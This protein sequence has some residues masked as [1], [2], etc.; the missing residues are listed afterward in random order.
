[1]EV[2]LIDL[3][4]L[5]IIYFG[6]KII[7]RGKVDVEFGVTNGAKY[8]S[9]FIKSTKASIDGMNARLIGV[10][11]FLMGLLLIVYIPVENVLFSIPYQ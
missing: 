1:M 10:G 6:A 9:K 3:F 4:G 2:G 7:A 5:L 11:F 8:R